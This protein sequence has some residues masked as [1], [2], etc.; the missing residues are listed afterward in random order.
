M[1][2]IALQVR[3]IN[4]CSRLWLAKAVRPSGAAILRLSSLF[5]VPP[6]AKIFFDRSYHLTI[7][8]EKSRL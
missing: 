8:A 2:S 4:V 7:T 5:L 3:R 1:A 6:S